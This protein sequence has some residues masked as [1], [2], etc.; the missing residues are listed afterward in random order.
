[1][2]VIGSFNE[3]RPDRNELTALPEGGIWE[4]FVPGVRQGDRYK[5]H[6]RSRF[7]DYWVDKADPYGVLHEEPPRT[8]SVVWDL[9]H[10]W[11]DDAWMAERGSRIAEDAPVSI[12]EVHPGSWRRRDGH[13][14]S[15]REL[16]PELTEYVVEHG[17]THVELMPIMEHPFYGSWG[18]Q[19]TGLFA[20]TARYGTPQDLMVLIETLHRAGVGVILD[21]VPSHFPTDEHGPAFFD[22]THL[23]EHADPRQGLHPDWRTYIYNF[24]AGGV[25][26][27]LISNAMHWL[28][29][30]HIDGLRVDAVASMLYLD[31]SR[32]D[33]EW[34]PNRYGGRENLDAIEFL[35]RLNTAVYGAFPDVQTIAEES[36]SWPQVSRPVYLGGLGF[37]MKWDMGWMHDTLEVLT[38][39][40]V[41]RGHHHE[42]LTFRQMYAWSESFVLALS[43]DEVV[44]GKRSLL[45]KM[46]GDAASK[47]A[48]LR[49]LYGYM[50]GLPGK[51]L[52]FMGDEFGQW[53]E[54]NHDGELSWELLDAAAHRGLQRWVGDLN[55]L[56]REEPALHRGDFRGDR[57]FRWVDCHDHAQ[58]VLSWLRQG[59]DDD[60]PVLVVCNFTPVARHEYRLGVPLAGR[61][62]EVLNG[63][64]TIYG[65]GGDGNLGGVDTEDVPSHDHPVSIRL[66]IPSFG[67]L[68]LRPAPA[69]AGDDGD[70]STNREAAPLPVREG[71][72]A[73]KAGEPR[74]A[75]PQSATDSKIGTP[76]RSD[77]RPT[78]PKTGGSKRGT[79][80]SRRK[81]RTK[82]GTDASTASDAAEDR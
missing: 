41:F 77:P 2:S 55:R 49:L 80:S 23:Y 39:D 57:G 16:A 47:F 75:D 8:A 13:W 64:A 5:F 53:R 35:R 36:T 20:P 15:Y 27:F 81:T 1:V 21:W 4:G 54:W 58:S 37:G 44:H 26:S 63:D 65:G 59:D 70:R 14:P 24:A 69:S 79:G 9:S 43:H 67:V 51:K 42:K 50:T 74:P 46:W 11:T 61:W 7:R 40:P 52:L 31:Y 56:Y 48:Q 62:D 82:G 32:K 71:G 30:Y 18:Y 29:R 10:T 76:P 45:D 78:R 22:G 3:W 34:I 33:G 66:T 73:G 19:V 72:D 12:Y 25:V 38:M 28:E 6:V 17:F 60:P 68:F